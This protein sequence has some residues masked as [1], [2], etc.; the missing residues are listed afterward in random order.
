MFKD[1]E[2]I[3]RKEKELYNT[4]Q[5][6][7]AFKK[8]LNIIRN[9][10]YYKM[11]GS[12]H[13]ELVDFLYK[14]LDIVSGDAYTAREI[15]ENRTFYFIIDGMGKGLSASLTAMIMTSFINHLID[16]MKLHDS[17]S[18]DILIQESM[19]YMKPILLDEES[20]SADYILMN[21]RFSMMEYAKFSMPVMLLED[22]NK[23]I[24]RLKSNNSSI[25]K[26]GND[27]Q[28]SKYKTDNIKKFLFYSDGLVENSVGKYRI[29]ADFIEKDFALS[30]TREDLKNKIFK[31]IKIQEDDI[32]LIFIN[33]LEKVSVLI[34]EKSFNTTLDDLDIANEWYSKELENTFYDESLYNSNIV[35]TELYMN[36]FEHG[37]L[38]MTS[39]EKNRLI[40]EDIYFETLLEKSKECTKKINV[41]IFKMQDENST[42]IVTKI[43][44]EGDGFDTQI[45]STIFRNSQTFNGRGVF[46]SR[47]NSFGI[48]Y[49]KKGNTVLYL[50][51]I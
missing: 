15:D 41:K 37:N 33:K 43:R 2:E 35:F 31:R 46:V 42:Y 28:V 5:E 20:I 32:T 12:E 44:D 8:E 39:V 9:D 1:G 38:G 7:L 49:N 25:T 11:I 16:K 24:I 14:P 30:Y 23:K 10:F 27:Y 47:K 36:A 6:D 45:L 13:I 26:Y 21:N 17:F 50:N 40:D 34:N 3:Q 51:K 29:Y 48:Y 4:Y 18:F 22:N 19:E